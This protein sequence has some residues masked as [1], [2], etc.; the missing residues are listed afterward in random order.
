MEDVELCFAHRALEPEEQAVVEI[1]GVV[2]TVLVQNERLAQRAQLEQAM[3]IRRTARQPRNLEPEHDTGVPQAN[4]GDQLLEADPIGSR[5]SGLTLITI[6]DD[7]LLGGPAQSD[8]SL[9]QR[10]LT[11]GALG[12]LN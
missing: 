11:G 9:A 1:A 7:D 2:Q 10:V 4:F 5:G 8:G 6:D 3:P 12:V